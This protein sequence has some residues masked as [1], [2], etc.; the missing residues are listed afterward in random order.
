[1]GLYMRYVSKG[2]KSKPP[3]KRVEKAS[4][5]PLYEKQKP[6]KSD[7][8]DKSRANTAN[9]QSVN[10][11]SKKKGRAKTKAKVKAKAEAFADNEQVSVST[12]NRTRRMEETGRK[13]NKRRRRNYTL[14]YILLFF[15]ITVTGVTLSL[16]VF[17]KIDTVVLTGTDTITEEQVVRTANIKMGSNLFLIPTSSMELAL[18]EAFVTV[19]EVD[20]TRHFPN[21][22]D[23]NITM[24]T[25]KATL[26]YEQQCYTMSSK[27]RILA[28]GDAPLVDDLPRV[29]GLELTDVKVGDLIDNKKEYCPDELKA[30]FSAIEVN[31]LENMSY[32][33]L[34]N[35]LEISIYIGDSYIIQVGGRLELDYKLH[36]AK[37]LLAQV[38]DDNEK[39][40]I[41]VSVDN[42]MYSFRPSEE[43]NPPLPNVVIK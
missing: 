36:C 7:P 41:N 32:I 42:G 17:F 9:D 22:V 6:A 1:M 26:L 14:Y 24:A 20:V 31:E 4:N 40:I 34:N 5:E 27:N 15:I 8:P 16:T 30:I 33:D 43:I 29:V 3:S 37:E 25:P 18:R 10:R 19:D 21:R 11:K 12:D 39:G 35:P 23:V 38:I 28:I 13:R 2:Q